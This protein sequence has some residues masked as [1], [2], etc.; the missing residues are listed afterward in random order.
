MFPLGKTGGLIEAQRGR[1][2][3]V[4][5]LPVFPLGKTGGLIEAEDR[6]PVIRTR[7]YMTFPLGKTGGLIEAR[8]SPGV[9]MP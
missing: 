5:D 7:S 8:R 9:L 3:V 2:F 1:G 4:V 6:R